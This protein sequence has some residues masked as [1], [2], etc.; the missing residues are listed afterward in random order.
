MIALALPGD[1]GSMTL[2]FFDRNFFAGCEDR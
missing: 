2:R 1:I